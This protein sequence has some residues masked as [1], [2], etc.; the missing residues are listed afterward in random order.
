ME[1]I[2]VGI[3]IYIIINYS[4]NFCR[5][6]FLWIVKKLFI[7]FF[8]PKNQWPYG[9]MISSWEVSSASVVQYSLCSSRKKKSYP[10]QGIAKVIGNSEG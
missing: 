7:Y 8:L 5:L 3:K 9:C 1:N 2:P 4:N 6:N 10:P